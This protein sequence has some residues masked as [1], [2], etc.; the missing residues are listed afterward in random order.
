MEILDNNEMD[1]LLSELEKLPSDR[2]KALAAYKTAKK[3]LGLGRSERFLENGWKWAQ[4][5]C[6]CLILPLAGFLIYYACFDPSRE[7]VKWAEVIVA[8]KDTC[9]L[10]LPDGSRLKINSGSRVTYPETFRGDTRD[11]F[12][13]GEVLA[14]IT[15]NPSHPFIIHSGDLAVKVFGT[16]F[17]FK[18]YSKSDFVEVYL[19]EGSVEFDV[20][21]GT[22]SQSVSMVPGELLQYSKSSG[23][24]D[25]KPFKMDAKLSFDQNG[26]FCFKDIP[27]GDIAND[28]KIRFDQNIIIADKE[29]ESKRIYAIFSNNERIEQI[30]ASISVSLGGPKI[31]KVGNTF[32]IGE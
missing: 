14:D 11:I 22:R 4:R 8:A 18:T 3:S 16:K 1:R 7:A 21:N 5:A 19:M 24:I 6:V 28:L 31:T 20:D 26:S 27:L 25:K 17:N 2:K 9:S 29:L 12:L 13:D 15:T 23:V 10:V 32:I 30:L